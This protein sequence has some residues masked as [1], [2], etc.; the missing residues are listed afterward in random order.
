MTAV[1]AARVLLSGALLA[2]AAAGLPVQTRG[3][4]GV[5]DDSMTQTLLTAG[6]AAALTLRYAHLSAE[7]MP[8]VRRYNLFW[9]SLEAVPSSPTLPASCPPGTQVTPASEAARVARGYNRYHC[10]DAALLERFDD[11][12]ARDAAIGAAS[13]IIAYGSP[14]WAQHP[15]CTGFPWPPNPNYKSG[16]LPWDALPD[17]EDYI[18]L[19]VERWH[20]PWGSGRASVSAL[21]I[22]NEWQS[23]GGW[24]DGSP[25][26]P[27]RATGHEPPFFTPAQMAVY[28]GMV[29][30]M[31]LLAGRAAARQNPE[32]VMLWLS[33]DHFNVA[34]KLAAGDIGHIGL[35]EL[36]DAV[37]PLV[38]LTVPWGIAVHPYDAGDPRA[39]LSAHG[40]YTFATLRA[41]VAE[42]QCR[43][44]AEVA[45]VPLADCYAWPQTQMWASEQGWPQGPTM[46]KTLQ[47]RNICLAHELSLAQRLWAVTHNMF[48]GATPSNQGGG[49]DYSL[50]DEPPVIAAN[51]SS[52]AQS[53]RDTYLAY[54]STAPDVFGLT[55]DHY[56]CTRWAVGCMPQ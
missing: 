48:Q 56:C 31:T 47:G 3:V 45:G 24:A 25:V 39:N 4:Q 35:Y 7:V 13:G 6:D 29:A 34:P 10:Y 22:W 50:I 46:N 32:N 36:L 40:I 8:G 16:C 30:N 5:D 17:W 41:D 37:W 49:G 43:K 28:A 54:M 23:C 20:A 14:D 21:C 38:N 53:N 1:Q 27:N 26:L 15:G 2:S 18:N 9:S 55:D 19:L 11:I 51:L 52:A 44:L 12:L 33:T 42:Y